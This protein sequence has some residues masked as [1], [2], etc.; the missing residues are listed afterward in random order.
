MA[1]SDERGGMEAFAVALQS[2]F[3]ARDDASLALALLGLL[4]D[5]R[6]VTATTQTQTRQRRPFVKLTLWRRLS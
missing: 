3:P 4:S 6:A 1:D 5:G 2:T